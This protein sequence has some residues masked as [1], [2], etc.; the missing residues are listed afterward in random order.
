MCT[1]CCPSAVVVDF[2]VDRTVGMPRYCFPCAEDKS[3]RAPAS[4]VSFV[5]SCSDCLHVSCWSLSKLL[6]DIDIVGGTDERHWWF[7][8]SLW[9]QFVDPY[10]FVYS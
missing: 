3:A 6:D 1:H 7:V 10:L 9:L 2:A 5:C 4:L 8:V